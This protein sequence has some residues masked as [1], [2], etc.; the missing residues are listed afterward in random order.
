MSGL[1]ALFAKPPVPGLVKTRLGRVLGPERAAA[2]A[3]A[4]LEDTCATLAQLD[5][6]TVL[7][8]T[9]LAGPFPD[10]TRTLVRWS[11]GEGDLGQRLT[12]VLSRAVSEA[13]WVLAVGADSPGLPAALYRQAVRALEDGAPA[14]LGPALDGGFYL[15][16]LAQMP[17]GLFDDIPWSTPDTGQAMRAR[18]ERFGLTP[19]ILPPWFDVDEHV[20]LGRLRS[21]LDA[22][23]I[24][25]PATALDLGR[26]VSASRLSAILPTLDEAARIGPLVTRLRADPNI[27]EVI[28]IDGGSRDDTVARAR[29]AG[30]HATL[31]PRGRAAQMN[32]GAALALGDHLVFVHADVTPLPDTGR[33]VLAALADPGVALAAFTTWTSLEGQRSW[34]G[35]LV[36]LADVRSRV[37][38]YPYGDQVMA[39][40]RVDFEA[41]GGFPEQPLMEDLEL[42]RRLL[43][44]GRLT[45]L[46]PPVVV[47][48]RRLVDRPLFTTLLW[49]LYPTLYRLG[50]DP[51]MLA[52]LYRDVR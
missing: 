18:L 12:T 1:I 4:F 26:G 28:V 43:R 14:V 45:R 19:V 25:A 30:A 16:G 31:G 23:S 3:A 15:L 48:G 46:S 35:P 24:S 39:M 36:H 29:A 5:V 21:L 42:S 49:N 50:I 32:G 51:E 27:A 41:V 47:S 7:A 37:S 34:L 33:R 20:D 40:R 9:D 13:N 2:L 52:R 10:R 11:Q 17:A 22:G 44:R 38:R 6:R 8:T